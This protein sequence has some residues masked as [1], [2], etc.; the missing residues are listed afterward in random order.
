MRSRFL[1][2]SL[3]LASVSLAHGQMPPTP[4]P[5]DPLTAV[6]NR[7]DLDDDARGQIRR[8]VEA[9]VADA[10]G[11][12]AAAARKAPTA[13]RDGYAGSD[14]FKRAY[15]AACL[16]V[17]GNAAKQPDFKQADVVPATRL[18]MVLSAL[19]LV[20]AQN[21]LL[22]A[23]QDPRVAVREAAALGLRN[24]RIKLVQAGGDNWT[25]VVT[26]LKDAGKKEKARDP[27]KAMYGALNYAELPT[28][29]DTRPVATALL[30]LLEERA[31]QY[32]AGKEVPALGADDVGLQLAESLLKSLEP[33]QKRRLTI[34]T[35]TMMKYALE[36]YGAKK[37]SKVADTPAAKPLA[38]YRNALERLLL[39][40]E[41]LL[42][43][44]LTPE[45]A[46]AVMDALR[47]GDRTA[48]KNQWNLWVALLQKAVGQDFSLV[49]VPESQP[50]EEEGDEGGGG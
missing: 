26:A 36:E 4:Q 29:P 46:P 25:K 24:L 1:L 42:V 41:R 15:A 5:E 27:L 3:L 45:K 12:D 35:A 31:K 8:F 49:E 38:E 13:L 43:P 50:T 32:V 39:V 28:P 6:R 20:E 37:L 16:E 21:V 10:R 22:D 33:D 34:V 7:T 18:I 2:V 30:E 48:A 14:A 9:R 44:L 11:S 23:L 17:I 19:N 40:G 47:K